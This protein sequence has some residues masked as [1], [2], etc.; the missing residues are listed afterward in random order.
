MWIFMRDGFVSVVKAED[1]VDGM[2]MI[3]SRSKVHLAQCFP[4][5]KDTIET[6]KDRDYM[7]RT[8]CHKDFFAHFMAQQIN[9]IDYTNFKDSVANAPPKKGLL[10]TLY[11]KALTGVWWEMLVFQETLYGGKQS[12]R[13]E[14]SASHNLSLVPKIKRRHTEGRK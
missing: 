4:L 7:F 3:R 5:L 12:A 11:K 10:K 2:L 8:Y 1:R 9:G 13:K 14:P 6:T